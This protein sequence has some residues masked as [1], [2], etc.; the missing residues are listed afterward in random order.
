MQLTAPCIK[1]LSSS[2]WLFCALMVD[3]CVFI[4]SVIFR[5]LQAMAHRHI[6]KAML[7]AALGLN[8][9][10]SSAQGGGVVNALGTADASCEV[11]ELSVVPPK[12]WLTASLE[13]NDSTL[14]VCQMA[15][16]VE[17]SLYGYVRVSSFD[18]SDTP[19]DAAP[20]Y[21]QVVNVETA[22]IYKKGYTLGEFVSSEKNIPITGTGF[23]NARALVVAAELKTNAYDQEVHFLVFESDNY[24]YLITLL[25]PAESVQGGLYYHRNVAGKAAVMQSLVHKP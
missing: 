2:G 6:F 5:E 22:S 8:S 25:T 16:V 7:I 13:T 24:K 18:L 20:W 19:A 15:L 23:R 11:A 14:R 17:G 10:I 1:H 4:I 3:N 12:G 21:Q 9:L